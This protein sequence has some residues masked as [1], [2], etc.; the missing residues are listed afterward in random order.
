MKIH[1]LLA[2]LLITSITF[3]ALPSTHVL[4]Q[5][6][7]INTFVVVIDPGHGGPERPGAVYNSVRAADLNLA[8]AE[9][10]LYL[11]N[12]DGFMRAYTTRSSDTHISWEDRAALANDVGDFMI[13]IHHNASENLNIRGVETFYLSNMD[14]QFRNITSHNF[15]QLV[16]HNLVTHTGRH[17][18]R[19]ESAEFRVLRYANVPAA[20]VELGFMSNPQEFATLVSEEYQWRAAKGLY[21]ALIEAFMWHVLSQYQ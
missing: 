5:N 4:A 18:R 20:L 12:R 9:K 13:T 11:I 15:A 2:A 16:Q 3:L 10:L 7:Q 6:Q 8:V 1:K 14:D 21:N 19:V 17:N